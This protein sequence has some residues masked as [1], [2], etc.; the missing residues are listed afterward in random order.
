MHPRP[1]IIHSFL[2]SFRL[3]PAAALICFGTVVAGITLAATFT[4]DATAA[5]S[6]QAPPVINTITG[7]G[8]GDGLPAKR[9]NVPTVFGTAVDAIGNLYIADAGNHRVRKIDTSGVIT[10]V[11]GV[12]GGGFGGDGGPATEALLRD[13]HDVAFDSSGNLYIADTGNGR[14]RRVD[15]S[16][17]ISTA[18]GRQCYLTKFGERCAGGDGGPAMEAGLQSPM[19]IAF[20]SAGSLYISDFENNVVRKVDSAGII[21]TVLDRSAGGG[22]N[23]LYPVGI[24][25]DSNDNLY[26]ADYF[27]NVIR[28]RDQAGTLTIVAGGGNP[29]VGNG[30]GGPATSALLKY[31]S[32]VATDAAGNLYVSGDFE[33]AVR[34]VDAASGKISAYAG[35]YKFAYSGNGGPAANAAIGLVFGL[36]MDPQGNLYIGC[37]GS[38][39][40]AAVPTPPTIPQAWNTGI[41]AR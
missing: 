32:S 8:V 13:P 7:A 24:T 39:G 19:S 30:D 33:F 2:R 14:I 34:K 40:G 36:D 6:S 1:H 29:A 10:T 41:C 9:A 16:G 25:V 11:A 4:S 28:R 17:T 38:G 3:Y 20:D 35:N 15:A 37:W 31:P 18:V 22:E 26:V 12:G 23:P 21:T 5:D 27:N